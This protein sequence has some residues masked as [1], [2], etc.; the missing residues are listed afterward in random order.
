MS[1]STS[2]HNP[3]TPISD[4]ARLLISLAKQLP[5]NWLAGIATSVGEVHQSVRTELGGASC[6]THLTRLADEIHTELDEARTAVEQ[7]AAGIARHA[8][9]HLRG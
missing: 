1:A 3:S 6:S 2:G 9:H 7:L 8:E 5:R 4:Q